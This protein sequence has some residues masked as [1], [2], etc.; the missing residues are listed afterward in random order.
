VIDACA[1]LKRDPDLAARLKAARDRLPPTRIGKHGQVMEWMEDFDEPEPGHRHVSHLYG[2]HPA[3]EITPRGTP[4]LAAAARVTLK[5]R[6]E[7]G[8]AHTGWSRA[9]LINFYARLGDGDA[10]REHLNL[11]LTKSTAD[12][13]FD[14]HPPFQIDGNF[15]ACAGVAEMLLQSQAGEI[16]LLPALPDAWPDGRVTGLR[17]RGGVTVDLAWK[18]GKLTEATLTADRAGTRA[19]RLPGDDKPRQ[20]TLKAGHKITLP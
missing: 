17:A 16:A 20:V 1:V 5:R 8:G 3:A 9:W 2:L 14:L 4:D 11:L 13:L 15:G 6:L 7:N 10:A 19:V 18:A 12:N